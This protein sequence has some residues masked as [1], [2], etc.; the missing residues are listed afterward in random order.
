MLF[1][2]KRYTLL[3]IKYA[4]VTEDIFMSATNLSVGQI[5]NYLLALSEKVKV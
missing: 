1:L 2:F 3:K 4:T 5:I